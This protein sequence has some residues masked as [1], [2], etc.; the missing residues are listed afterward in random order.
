MTWKNSIPLL[1]VV[2]SASSFVLPSG[3]SSTKYDKSNPRG[4]WG[5]QSGAL[6]AKENGYFPSLPVKKSSSSRDINST[7][8]IEKERQ[9][10][11]GSS[12]VLFWEEDPSNSKSDVTE[13]KHP[14]Q[15][16]SMASS[17]SLDV[18]PPTQQLH[19]PSSS[20]MVVCFD[21]FSRRDF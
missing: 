8:D 4:A 3:H 17:S 20:Q 1:P 16:L 10:T 7:P 18:A 6:V 14:C 19:T 11:G 5:Q 9:Q 21:I 15:C 12:E 13:L 2:G